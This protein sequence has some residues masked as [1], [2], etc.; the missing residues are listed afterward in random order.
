MKRDETKVVKAY[1]NCWHI[2][3]IH[4]SGLSLFA[5]A[6]AAIAVAVVVVIVLVV[7]V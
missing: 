1:F 4:L 3:L 7:R 2:E 6:V 5:I